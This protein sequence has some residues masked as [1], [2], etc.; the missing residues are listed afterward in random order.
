MKLF[1]VKMLAIFITLYFA[2][3]QNGETYFKNVAAFAKGLNIHQKK[4]DMG[5]SM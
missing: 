2:M 3:S 5:S 1:F 4:S